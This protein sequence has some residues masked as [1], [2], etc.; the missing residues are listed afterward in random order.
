[1][2]GKGR[3]P[4]TLREHVKEAGESLSEMK[5]TFTSAEVIAWLSDQYTGHSFNKGSIRAHISMFTVNAHPSHD[6]YTGEGRYWKKYPLFVK[7]RR[8]LYRCYDHDRDQELY[9][10]EVERDENIVQG[11]MVA[12]RKGH[13]EE[14]SP[15]I[16]AGSLEMRPLESVKATTDPNAVAVLV[17]CVKSKEGVPMPAKDI[18]ISALFRRRRTYAE[19]SGRPWFILSSL[20]GLVEPDDVIE[21]YEFVITS[22]TA[23]ERIVWGGQVVNDLKVRFGPLEGKVFEVHA[24]ANYIKAFRRQLESEGASIAAPLRHL[25]Q[26]EQ[27]QWYDQHTSG[28]VQKPGDSIPPRP[29]STARGFARSITSAFNKGRLDLS[30]RYDA[31]APGWDGMPECNAVDRMRDRGASG[32][33]IR[34]FLSFIAAMDRARD[35]D[36]LWKA[37]ERL[38]NDHPWVFDPNEV[39]QRSLV[40]LSDTLRSYGVSQRH[41]VDVAAWRVI[42]ET[43]SDSEKAPLVRDAIFKGKGDV[44]KLLDALQERTTEGTP[45]FPMLK[46][47]KVGPMLIR[48][49]VLPGGAEITSLDDLPVAVD[50]QVRKVTEYLGASDTYGMELEK[51][52]RRIQRIWA[53]D[54]E[55]SGADG[56]P[57]LDGTPAALDPALWFFGKWGC[58]YCERTGRKI[59]IAEVCDA[60]RFEELTRRIT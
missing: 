10:F 11:M 59:P 12:E 13:L 46:G 20:Y 58:T 22:M 36:R 51:V 31:P 37:G 50:V 30:Q 17:G 38:F 42:A 41:S 47:P 54:V 48:M 5:G 28:G 53:V 45:L 16:R 33:E 49:L 4:K 1:M 7:V 56:P 27:L 35:A 44:S 18:Y 23:A 9:R 32:T 6:Q 39:V 29:H 14:L 52:R 25:R 21:P 57:P 24:G 2:V 8:G 26:G 60:C 55:E 40:E 15:T 19:S 3:Y 34:L 43:L